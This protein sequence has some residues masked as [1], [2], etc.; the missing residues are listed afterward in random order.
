MFRWLFQV[1]LP[2]LV[3]ND[4]LESIKICITDGDSQETSQLDYAIEQVM[5]RAIRIHCAWHIVS[6][7]LK[8][9]VSLGSQK[10]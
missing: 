5:K 8:K 6:Q 3:G 7:G 4:V 10:G 2:S 9:Q 1:A